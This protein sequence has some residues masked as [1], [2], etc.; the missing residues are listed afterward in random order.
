[1]K[2]DPVV[3]DVMVTFKAEVPEQRRE[4]LLGI[5]ARWPGVTVA[6][7]LKRD[8]SAAFRRFSFVR[9][10]DDHAQHV[11]DALRKLPEVEAAELA[12]RRGL[13]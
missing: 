2:G 6:A 12:P 10:D 1:M 4:F 9:V 13:A 8:A 5:M 3:A 11:T 7:P